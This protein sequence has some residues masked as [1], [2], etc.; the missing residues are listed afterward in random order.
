MSVA[1]E[2]QCDDPEL[3]LHFLH[4]FPIGG[5]PAVRICKKELD[6][7]SDENRFPL[8]ENGRIL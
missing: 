2:W 3:I 5:A 7:L 8:S 1:P 6:P 4:L